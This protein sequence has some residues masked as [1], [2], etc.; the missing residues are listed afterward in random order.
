MESFKNHLLN[1]S[2]KPHLWSLSQEDE[3][4][5]IEL[6]KNDFFQVP[7]K[8]RKYVIDSFVSIS[9]FHKQQKIGPNQVVFEFFNYILG[10]LIYEESG[11]YFFW[12]E[13]IREKLPQLFD[14]NFLTINQSLSE[15]YFSELSARLNHIEKLRF[16]FKK[17]S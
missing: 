3:K 9:F 2:Q 16:N 5:I 12:E 13:K 17:V 7:D 4:R 15:K 8:Y 6:F 14:Y 11:D 1:F 10:S